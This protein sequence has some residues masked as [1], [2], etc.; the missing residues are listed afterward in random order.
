MSE[1]DDQNWGK[2]LALGV[3]MAAAVLLGLFVGRWLDRKF[4]WTPWGTLIG[5]MLGVATGMYML[6]KDAIRLNK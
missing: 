4:D 2:L 6:I 5:A 1:K 3:E